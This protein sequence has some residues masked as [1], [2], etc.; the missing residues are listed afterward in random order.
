M[1][2]RIVRTLII[3][4]L[5]ATAPQ[6]FA[7]EAQ[8]TAQDG[9]GG[10]ALPPLGEAAVRAL[11]DAIELMNMDQLDEAKAILTDLDPR[12]LSPFEIGRVQ[13]LLAQIAYEQDDFAKSREHFQNAIDSGGVSELEI[14]NLKFQIAQLLV[15]DDLFAEAVVALEEWFTLV[16]NPNATAYYLAAGVYYQVGNS[17]KALEYARKAVELSPEPQESHLDL[18]IALLMDSDQFEEARGHLD[19]ILTLAPQ[20]KK[21]WIQLSSVHASTE[22]F[23]EALATMEIPYLAGLLDQSNEIV[24]YTDLLAYNG[25]T[26]RCATVL[27]KA[28]ADGVVEANLQNNQKLANCWQQSQELDKAVESLAR[29]APLSETGREYVRLGEVHFRLQNWDEAVQAFEAGINKGGIDDVGRV[30]LL[31]GATYYSSDEPCRAMPWFERARSSTQQRD[32]A[33]EYIRS[34]REDRGC[35]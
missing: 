18:L 26:Y 29:V 22:N 20:K 4:A 3:A 24:R 19:R 30:Q 21:Y 28:S 34:L 12:R 6:G 2:T 11:N 25:L 32:S 33:N 10:E 7:Q 16:D 1:N 8:R 13:Q 31:A 35:Q 17:A 9:Q 15:A 14:V 5:I 23:E 27:E